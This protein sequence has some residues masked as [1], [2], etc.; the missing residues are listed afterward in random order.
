[1]LT[2]SVAAENQVM[3]MVGEFISASNT[4]TDEILALEKEKEGVFDMA[5]DEAAIAQ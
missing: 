1:M 4:R 5:R 2:V 3:R